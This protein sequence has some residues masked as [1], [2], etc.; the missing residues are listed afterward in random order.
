VG[1]GQKDWKGSYLGKDRDHFVQLKEDCQEGYGMG[2]NLEHG[3]A[4]EFVDALVAD[5]Q[6]LEGWNL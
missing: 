4:L 6:N 5:C 3:V 2:S 1:A